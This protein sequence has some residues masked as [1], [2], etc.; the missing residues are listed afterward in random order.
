MKE[1]QKEEQLEEG[2]EP[3]GEKRAYEAEE[4]WA[5]HLEQ[6]IMTHVQENDMKKPLLVTW[7]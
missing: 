2:E 6:S 7:T 4:C 1:K 3:A 5:E